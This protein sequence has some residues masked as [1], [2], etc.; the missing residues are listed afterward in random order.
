MHTA[1]FFCFVLGLFVSENV[2]MFA[3]ML[4]MRCLSTSY[5]QLESVAV[6]LSFLCLFCITSC[7]MIIVTKKKDAHTQLIEINVLSVYSDILLITRVQ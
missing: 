4:F 6:P 7:S 2:F 1:V 3:I 5:I